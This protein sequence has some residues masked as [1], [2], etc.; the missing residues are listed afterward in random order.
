[1]CLNSLALMEATYGPYKSGDYV[2]LPK[3]DAERLISEGLASYI[4]Q[5]PSL[6]EITET[7]SSISKS[8]ETLSSSIESL[9]SSLADLNARVSAMETTMYAALAISIIAA[10]L[11][12]VAIMRAGK[13]R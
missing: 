2:K 9:N 6:S 1:M 3:E 4:K 10:I 11:A 12:I 5:E 8:V 7:L 13:R